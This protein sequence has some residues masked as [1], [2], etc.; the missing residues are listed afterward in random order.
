MEGYGYSMETDKVGLPSELVVQQ[1]RYCYTELSFP[2]LKYV[3]KPF[4]PE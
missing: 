1:Y 2:L 4:L 3:V